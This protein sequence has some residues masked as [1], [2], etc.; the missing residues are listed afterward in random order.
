MTFPK[1]TPPT[2]IPVHPTQVYEAV[3]SLGFFFFL[4]SRRKAWQ[5]R[6][7]F[8]MA[9][10]LLLAG[11]ERFGVEYLRTNVP[12]ALGLTMAQWISV[13]VVAIGLL[14]LLR[15]RSR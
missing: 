4:W 15:T 12:V 3:L 2:T 14:L 13:G 6:P 10:Y 1:G 9:V 7:G 8:T 5:D 11:T